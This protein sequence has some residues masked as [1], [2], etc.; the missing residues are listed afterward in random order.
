MPGRTQMT[1][2]LEPRLDEFE[3]RL[4]ALE[5][6][7]AELRALSVNGHAAVEAEATEPLGWAEDLI[8][9][10]D[11]RALLRRIERERRSAL[12]H[13]ELGALLELHGIVRL[14]EEQAPVGVEAELAGLGYTIR[15]NARYVARRLG[16]E[17][18]EQAFGAPPA[19]EPPATLELD[20]ELQTLREQ[21][22]TW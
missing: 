11:F 19:P 14:A 20:H 21:A 8:A 9:R 6:E 15:Q 3:R 16:V 2:P 22:P 5:A 4:R 17:L 18:D 10:G 1:V 13:E 7:L 12:G